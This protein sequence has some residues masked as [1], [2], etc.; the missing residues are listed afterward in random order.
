MIDEL[1]HTN[2]PGHAQREALPGHRRGARR[3]HRRHLDRQ[4]PAP[5]EPERRDLRADRGPRARDVPR[6][7]P[8]RGRRGRARRPDA[9]GA[10]GA[11][12]AGKV[13]PQE[14]AEVALAE[15]LPAR[16]PRGAARARAARGRRG[17]RGAARAPTVLDPLSQQAVAERVLALVEPQ[18]KSQRI[19]RRA[20]RSAQRLGADIDALWVRRPGRTPSRRG[21]D[22]ARRAAA[23][24]ERP[25]RP[26]PRGGGRRPRR[27][28]A[29]RRRRARLDL[30][31][32]RHARRVPPP[33]DLRRLA[34][35]AHGARAARRR[36]PR[37]REPRRPRAAA[38]NDRRASIALAALVARSR[39]RARRC[40][41]AGGAAPAA[42]AGRGAILVPFTGGTLD[43][44]VLD[45]AI[46]H[47]ARRGRDARPGLPPAR[48]ARATPRTRR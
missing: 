25:R 33:R 22:A 44:T 34:P 47:R 26:L 15:L 6:P 9:R 40:A 24:R 10:A 31:L 46:R 35:L 41:A 32:R 8:R 21:S 23:A 3:R 39:G 30:R 37:R 12:R 43:P 38:T 18:P 27:D 5:R 42:R 4:R 45:A 28:R 13:Y 29:A 48:A 2:A 16:Q 19:L 11:P 1:A 20:W 7:R 17:R 36:H 14:R